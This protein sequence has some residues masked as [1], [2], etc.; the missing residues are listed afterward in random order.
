MLLNVSDDFCR[1]KSYEK[2]TKELS[3][4]EAPNILTIVLKRFQ[5]IHLNL[6]ADSLCVSA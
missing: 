5:V 3:V 2:A 4:L 1:C 6:T